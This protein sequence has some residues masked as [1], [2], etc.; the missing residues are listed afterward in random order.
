M[1]NTQPIYSQAAIEMFTVAN[2]YCIFIESAHKYQQEEVHRFLNRILPLMY[3]KGSLLPELE[4]EY[5]EA[6]ERYLT[7]EQ[8]ENLFNELRFFF[9]NTD[10][11][12]SIDPTGDASD[13]M[14]QS[15]AENLAD[16]YQD[17]KDFVLLFSKES[18]AAKENALSSVAVLFR[19]HWGHRVLNSLS[20][21]HYILHHDF[22]DNDE[23]Y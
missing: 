2:E 18:A 4:V 7:A 6:N 3:L 1:T 20:Y 5:P 23:L 9:A 10:V 14:R 16:I 21:L 17:M 13:I 11:F 8:W 19:S 12:V 22:I 15:L